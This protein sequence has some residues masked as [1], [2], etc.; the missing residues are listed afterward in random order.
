MNIR[1]ILV[2]LIMLL[3]VVPMWAQQPTPG[4]AVRQEVDPVRI[5]SEYKVLRIQLSAEYVASGSLSTD[6]IQAHQLL[7]GVASHHG[8]VLARPPLRTNDERNLGPAVLIA[9]LESLGLDYD[10]IYRLKLGL[11]VTSVTEPVSEL[12]SAELKVGK[13]SSVRE[14][15]SV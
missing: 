15:A 6:S 14:S 1:V 9:L 7:T 11:N 10:R 5:R 12:Q 2:F 8:I 13:R 3:G 4:L